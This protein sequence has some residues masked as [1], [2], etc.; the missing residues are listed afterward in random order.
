MTLSP[1]TTPNAALP[2]ATKLANFML[3]DPPPA[4]TAGSLAGSERSESRPEIRGMAV[5]VHSVHTIHSRNDAAAEQDA[6]S[7]H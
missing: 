4:V 6:D 3:F 1:V 7:S 5:R 2:P